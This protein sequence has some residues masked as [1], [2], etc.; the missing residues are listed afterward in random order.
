MRNTR[1]KKIHK[2]TQFVKKCMHFTQI[3]TELANNNKTIKNSF[4]FE[5]QQLDI[6]IEKINKIKKKKRKLKLKKI[7]KYNN[8]T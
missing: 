2:R 6:K 4:T 3:I 1:P 7:K 5:K 8:N